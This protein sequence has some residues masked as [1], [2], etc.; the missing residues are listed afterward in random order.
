VRLL[1][2]KSGRAPGI[3]RLPFKLL[4]YAEGER[5]DPQQRPQNAQVLALTAVLNSALLTRAVTRRATSPGSVAPLLY[6]P[7]LHGKTCQASKVAK[8]PAEDEVLHDGKLGQDLHLVHLDHALVHLRAP[9]SLAACAPC[10]SPPTAASGGRCFLVRAGAR[11]D[12]LLDASYSDTQAGACPERPHHKRPHGG[13]TPSPR[14]AR[15]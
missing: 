13:R 3:S 15:R 6:T 5:T 10:L 2:L 1:K 14:R 7:D 4:R 12:L 8:Q 9:R 11:G